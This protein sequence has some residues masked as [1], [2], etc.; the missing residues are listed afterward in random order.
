MVP[1]QVELHI[2]PLQTWPP[3][4]A[5]VQVPQCAASFATHEP[6]HSS[7]PLGHAQLPDWQVRPPPQ[8]MPQLPQLF[9]SVSVFVQTLPQAFS[10]ALQVMP[11]PAAPAVPVPPFVP[12]V[13]GVL[14]PGLLHAASDR[15][16]ARPSPLIDAEAVVF[17]GSRIPGRPQ[18][19]LPTYPGRGAARKGR[20]RAPKRSMMLAS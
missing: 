8:G 6:P 9:E 20:D 4:H 17:I 5:F 16:N 15:R 14:P 18:G 10:G 12:A 1:A 11:V 3:V 7:I 2:P 13:P 19:D